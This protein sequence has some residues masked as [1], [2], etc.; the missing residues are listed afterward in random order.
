MRLRER[1]WRTL[2]S[3]TSGNKHVDMSCAGTTDPYT[4][5]ARTRATATYYSV[6]LGGDR[7]RESG[8]R[9]ETPYAAVAAIR[10]HVAFYPDRVDAIRRSQKERKK[11]ANRTESP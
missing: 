7:S 11:V 8:G 2:R 3:S 4:P 10:D 5:I 6:P 9:Y 1:G